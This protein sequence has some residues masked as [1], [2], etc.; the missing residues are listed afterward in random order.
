MVVGKGKKASKIGKEGPIG[1]GKISDQ[2][3]INIIDYTHELYSNNPKLLDEVR[4]KA[5]NDADKRLRRRKTNDKKASSFNLEP[6]PEDAVTYLVYP[7]Q[8]DATVS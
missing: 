2:S 6:D 4:L 1:V 7:P 5:K 8:T 3:L